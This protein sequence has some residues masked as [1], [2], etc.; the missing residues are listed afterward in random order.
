MNK[1]NT[2]RAAQTDETII[3]TVYDLMVYKK[4]PPQKI[5]VRQICDLCAIHRST[6]YAHYADVRDVIEKTEQQMS[7]Q[8]SL[9]FL[10][11]LN[12]KA[13]AP[14][15]FENLFSFIR[16]YREFYQYSLNRAGSSAEIS[17][18][19]DLFAERLDSADYKKLGFS[20][21]QEMD[22]MCAFFSSGLSAVIRKWVNGNCKETPA[23]LVAMLKKEA[24]RFAMGW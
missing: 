11:R 12:E 6:F 15:C 14:E 21:R 22:Y 9:S 10:E 16:E 1:K 13:S 8:L 3:R 2:R 23:E 4:I 18:A 19:L 17:I 5:T 24:P 20:S 7:K